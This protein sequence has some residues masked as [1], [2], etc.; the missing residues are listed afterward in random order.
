MR[1]FLEGKIDYAQDNQ[2]K[3]YGHPHVRCTKKSSIFTAQVNFRQLLVT[4]LSSHHHGPK[5][6]EVKEVHLLK[7]LYVSQNILFL[8]LCR[9]TGVSTQK[10]F[11][12][13]CIIFDWLI[14]ARR[15]IFFRCMK[16]ADVNELEFRP[17]HSTESLKSPKILKNRNYEDTEMRAF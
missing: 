17:T 4:N 16:L 3:A 7:L 2:S 1:S 6:F 5:L 10:W 12:I 15:T 13:A 9:D 8:F 14:F 11:I